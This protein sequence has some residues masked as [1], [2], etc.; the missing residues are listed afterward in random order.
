MNETPHPDFN[1]ELLSAYLDDELSVEERAAVE[2]RLE[3][4][5]A[6]RQLLE[7]L[8][9]ASQSVQ[10]LPQATAAID[11][12]DSV[13][14]RV[15]ARSSNRSE[16]ERRAASAAQAERPNIT[17]GRTRRG[18][19]WA[20]FAIAAALLVMFLQP[21][22]RQNNNL[23][24]VAKRD[25]DRA[26]REDNRNRE[27]AR[28]QLSEDSLATTAPDSP[29]TALPPIAEPFYE[30]LGAGRESEVAASPRA[31]DTRGGGGAQDELLDLSKPEQPVA[32]SAAGSTSGL[33]AAP[34]EPAAQG[35][36]EVGGRLGG[37]PAPASGLN[38]EPP[39]GS[40]LPDDA[41]AAKSMEEEESLIVVHVR[42]KPAAIQAK[43][44][45]HVL[46]ANGIYFDRDA[47]QARGEQ[48]AIDAV[49]E[50]SQLWSQD[51]KETRGKKVLPELN[52]EGSVDVVLVE[53]PPN[54]IESCVAQLSNDYVN[55]VSVDV[56]ESDRAPEAEGAVISSDKADAFKLMP[57]KKLVSDLGKY[58]RGFGAM[59]QKAR[60]GFDGD[61]PGQF[62]ARKGSREPH[63]L[64]LSEPQS[65]APGS[66]PGIQTESRWDQKVPSE[67]LAK[68]IGRAERLLVRDGHESADPKESQMRRYSASDAGTGD[69]HLR[70]A[71]RALNKPNKS[72]PVD[73]D[74]V[75]VLFYFRADDEPASSPADANSTK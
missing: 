5:P 69:V 70:G 6:A 9:S 38:G 59:E 53:A 54:A 31:A 22:E 26:P 55:C 20:A 65:Q 58:R 68:N 57:A 36:A 24:A 35:V 1:D 15:A 17:I 37:E 12:R 75:K 60:D 13:L 11:F 2:A 64:K 44:F 28:R 33:A 56:D 42:A 29:P 49:A 45:D 63:D 51:D 50:R 61:R 23:P 21:G 27:L 30:K 25:G 19:I 62:D 46:E 47:S 73:G 39:T 43:T 3:A 14:E 40:P 7:Q 74:H 72:G 4:D 41:V 67:K 8:R 34:A 71:A 10:R 52:S 48:A 16:D 66:N 18:W 32:P